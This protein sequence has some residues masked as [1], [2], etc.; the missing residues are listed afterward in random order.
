MS[1]AILKFNLPEER[2]DFEVALN[3]STYKV[4]LNTI[5]TELRNK[6]KYEEVAQKEAEIYEYVRRMI[7]DLESEYNLPRD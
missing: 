7:N 1:E 6:L 5:D 2:E 3:G 4:I